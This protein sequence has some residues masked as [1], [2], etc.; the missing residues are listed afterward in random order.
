MNLSCAICL[1]RSYC[2]CAAKGLVLISGEHL[3]AASAPELLLTSRF[4][5]AECWRWR[6]SA[7]RCWW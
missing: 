4:L 3:A 2:T 5:A 7:T 1:V 6:T